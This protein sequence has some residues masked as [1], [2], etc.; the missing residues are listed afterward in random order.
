M[1]LY[2]WQVY[3]AS[4]ILSRGQ[5]TERSAK[6]AVKLLKFGASPKDKMEFRREAEVMQHFNHPH[7][8]K[9]VGVT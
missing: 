3:A 2:T 7:L 9:L 5:P 8:I 6:R 1:L 4:Q